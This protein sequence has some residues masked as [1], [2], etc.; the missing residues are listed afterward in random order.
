MPIYDIYSNRNKQLPDVYTYE[1]FTQKFK[2]QVYHI[3]LNFTVQDIFKKQDYKKFSDFIWEQVEK[4][5]LQEHGIKEFPSGSIYGSSPFQ[6]IEVYFY[7]ITEADK[8]IDI[9][10]TSL[11]AFERIEPIVLKYTRSA[12]EIHYTSDDAIRDLNHRFKENGLGYE[13]TSGKIIKVDSVIIH[14]Q[15]IKPA[16]FLLSDKTFENANDEFM[17]AH[18]HFRHGRYSECFNESLKAFETTLKITIT[19]NGWQVNPNATVKD[20]IAVC[21]QNELIPNYLQA[22]FSSLR[23]LLESGIPT[24]RKKNSAHGQGAN[25][26]S[27]PEYFASFMLYLTGSCIKFIIDA[28]LDKTIKK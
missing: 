26:I 13:Y 1:N 8:I 23:S 24:L 27:I 12:T 2:N 15:V 4:I 10:E 11:R 28:Q 21:F 14:E 25:K 6:N 20:L 16:L 19:V 17:K 3:W 5:I 7:G 18:E 9:I 22:Q